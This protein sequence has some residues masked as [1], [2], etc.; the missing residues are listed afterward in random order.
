MKEKA[1]T[2]TFFIVRTL[3]SD[4]ILI[5]TY[6]SGVLSTSLTHNIKGKSAH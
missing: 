3:G 5:P 2:A 1:D 6:R 4:V